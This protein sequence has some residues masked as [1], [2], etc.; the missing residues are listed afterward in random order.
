MLGNCKYFNFNN[1]S[2]IVSKGNKTG[3]AFDNEGGFRED[4]PEETLTSPKFRIIAPKMSFLLGGGC[5]MGKI[6]VELLV[7][8]QVVRKA[9]ANECLD[10]MRRGEWDVRQFKNQLGRLRFVAASGKGLINFDDLWAEFT[11]TGKSLFRTQT[12][13]NSW[14]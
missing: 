3:R 2:A 9:V 6:R 5:D 4:Y 11:C 14:H 12:E 1:G 7:N 10:N 13:A 8:G